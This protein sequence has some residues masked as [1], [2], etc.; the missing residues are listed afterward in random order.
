M[1]VGSNYAIC[2]CEAWWLAKKKSPVSFS[3]NEKQNF[4]QSPLV[5]AIFPIG[6]LIGSSNCLL[7]LWLVGVIALYCFFR[8]S[9]ENH[10]YIAVLTNRSFPLNNDKFI[11]EI[12]RFSP[13]IQKMIFLLSLYGIFMLYVWT[14]LLIAYLFIAYSFCQ[15]GTRW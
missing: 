14:S 7:L 3:A 12:E 13:F 6:F 4:N 10:S 5:R 2:D 9:F 8:Q 1:T 11:E 15:T